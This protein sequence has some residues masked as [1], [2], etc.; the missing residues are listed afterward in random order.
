MLEDAADVVPGHVR[1]LGVSGLVEEQRFAALLLAGLDGIQNKIEPPAPVDKDIY[2]LP[3][4]EHAAMDHVPGSLGAV[5]DNLEADHEFLLAGDV[6]TP[7]LIETWV[8]LKRGDLAALQQ[9]PHPYEFDL[10]Y[11][12]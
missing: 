1:E 3:P 12:I 10:Y 11:D 9:R 4:E 2:E 8:E 6:F 7:D 5:L